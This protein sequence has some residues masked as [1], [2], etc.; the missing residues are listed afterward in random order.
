MR[1]TATAFPVDPCNATLSFANSQ[2]VAIGPS[3]TVNLSP[4]RSSQPLDLNSAA[5]NLSFGQSVVVQPMVALQ[6]P[7]GA[8]AVAG[9]A[10]MVASDVFDPFA[11]RTWTYQ[12]ANVQ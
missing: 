12:I 2:G 10:C 4:G 7:I 5:L 8:A 6:Q 1:L 3:L 9:S 11:G